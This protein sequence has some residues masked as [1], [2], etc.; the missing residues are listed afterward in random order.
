MDLAAR[1]EL[2]ICRLKA[3]IAAERLDEAETLLAQ[4][5]QLPTAQDLL[6]APA[7]GLKKNLSGEPAS[8]GKA[9]AALANFQ[10]VLTAQ[11]DA[12]AVDDLAADIEK[13]KAAVHK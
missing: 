2:L 3:R 1:R 5:R 13:R 8:Q 10:K 9:D 11:L 6:A 7:A 4:L 12:K